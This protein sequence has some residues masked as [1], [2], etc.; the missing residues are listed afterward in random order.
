EVPHAPPPCLP[1]RTLNRSGGSPP[2]ITCRWARPAAASGRPWYG[3]A[4]FTVGTNVVIRPLTSSGSP[5]VKSSACE[6]GRQA[7]STPPSRR[8]APG[9]RPAAAGPSVSNIG[10]SPGLLVIPP[11]SEPITTETRKVP[12][13]GKSSARS[14]VVFGA[15]ADRYCTM[16]GGAAATP[17]TDTLFGWGARLLPGD[18]ASGGGGGV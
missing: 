16:S 6:P 5:G 18:R 14:R 2:V 10:D 11:D 1:A 12:S 15:S 13:F 9:V 17:S 8:V 4:P 3:P 7:T